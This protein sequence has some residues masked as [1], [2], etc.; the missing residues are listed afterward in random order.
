MPPKTIASVLNNESNLRILEMLK[1]RPYYPRELAAE[2]KLSEPFIVRRLKAME[3]YG[4]V[5]GRW[6]SENGRK[7]KRYYPLDITMQL[8]KDGLKV[9]SGEIPVQNEIDLRKE[10]MKFLINLPIIA[11]FFY[12]FY[13]ENVPI[14]CIL[15]FFVIWQIVINLVLYRTYHFKSM[16]SAVLLLFL[17]TCM[18]VLSLAITYSILPV[19]LSDSTIG[20]IYG[21]FGLFAVMTFIY[22]IR[23]SQ[24]EGKGLRTS[25]TDLIESLYDQP[26]PVKIFYF[27]MVIRWRVSEYWGFV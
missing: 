18:I 12:G 10:V 11:V 25:K 21:V 15:L 27:L 19:N 17:V 5:E 14:I 1:K 20:L 23:F 6:E 4:I 8:G 16:L 13:S 24:I 3:E 22:H 7:V 26:L 9:T 2:M